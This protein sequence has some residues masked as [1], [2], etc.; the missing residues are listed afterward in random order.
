[1]LKLIATGLMLAALSVL[2]AQST[3]VISGNVE[4]DAGRAACGVRVC[5][6]ASD[7]DPK[8][9]GVF[10]PCALTDA[11]G[12]FDIAVRK[13]GSYRLFY[14]YS[15]QGYLSPYL[16]FFRQPSAH[17]PEVTL[18]NTNVR[19]S[20]NISMMPRNG[21]LV[22]KS[23]DALTG[24]PV[25]SVEFVLCHAAHTEVCWQMGAKSSDGSFKIPAP[26][27]PFTVRVKAEGY[28]D[29]LGPEGG[30]VASP[31]SVAPETK[32]EFTVFMKRT[33]ASTGRAL[34]DAEKQPGVYLPAPAQTAPAD[35]AVFDYYPRLT[36][37][38]W[39]QVEGAVSY[40]VEVDY[41]SGETRDRA[42]CVNPQQHTALN[43]TTDRIVGITYEFNFVGAQPGRWRVWAVD[44]EGS[45]GFKSPWRRFVYTQ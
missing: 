9:P 18:D 25:E 41:C 39:S 43:P 8:K 29:W 3:Y 2:S 28:E 33:E 6:Y 16:P 10:I 12:R 14:D 19:A 17:V 20:V 15:E 38:E 22:G 21:L 35:G 5:A 34:S 1:M 11:R 40:T 32:S 37:L 24:N 13:A 27:V 31:L 26:H 23:I 30:V 44:K 45:E 36:K 7:F 42:G 4:D